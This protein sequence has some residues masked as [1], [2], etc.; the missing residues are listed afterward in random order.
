MAVPKKRKTGTRQAQRR[1]HDAL[2]AVNLSAC[3]H[4]GKPV[5]PH[6]MCPACGYYRGKQVVK[7]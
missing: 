5:R 1:S 7:V 2:T 6:Q 4:C 3:S